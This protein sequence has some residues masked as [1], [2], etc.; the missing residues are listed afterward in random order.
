MISFVCEKFQ[1]VSLK[2]NWQRRRA[3]FADCGWKAFTVQY[4]RINYGDRQS[5]T[6]IFE[7]ISNVL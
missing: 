2:L 6:C 1:T 5:A 3:C 7:D 4:L